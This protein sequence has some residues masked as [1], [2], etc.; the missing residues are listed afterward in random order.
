M[1]DIELFEADL[2]EAIRQQRENAFTCGGN[3][4]IANEW[5]EGGPP[6]HGELLLIVRN[7]VSRRDP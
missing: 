7:L 5:D 3:S 4:D 1:S 6:S 2:K